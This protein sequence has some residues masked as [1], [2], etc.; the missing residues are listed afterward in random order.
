MCFCLSAHHQ[1]RNRLCG[2]HV[3]TLTRTHTHSVVTLLREYVQAF[4]SS[5]PSANTLAHTP[6]AHNR[7][8]IFQPYRQAARS[9]RSNTSVRTLLAFCKPYHIMCPIGVRACALRV[10]APGASAVDLCLGQW[11]AR[12]NSGGKQAPRTLHHSVPGAVGH[13]IYESIGVW[14]VGETCGRVERA[15]ARARAC[16]VSA[17]NLLCSVS[18]IILQIR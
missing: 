9:A 18:S 7:L 13:T 11:C 8:V 6:P 16:C 4:Y 5:P 10:S 2:R 1:H 17:H 3:N 12:A 15:R 14:V